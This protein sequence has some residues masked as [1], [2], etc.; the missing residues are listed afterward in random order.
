[1]LPIKTL[2]AASCGAVS[3]VIQLD[4]SRD[5]KKEQG[6]LSSPLHY[7]ALNFHGKLGGSDMAS[8]VSI[9]G[10]REV[11]GADS[12]MRPEQVRSRIGVTLT[13]KPEE[14]NR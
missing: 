13:D 5:S 6:N 8:K 12:G 4:Q 7:L 3:H 1:M 9:L 14:G 2:Q 10:V 11:L